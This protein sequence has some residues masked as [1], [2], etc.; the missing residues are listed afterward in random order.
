M[1]D[2]IRLG[3]RRVGIAEA[4]RRRHEDTGSDQV[5]AIAGDNGRVAGTQSPHF[6]GRRH[7]GNEMVFHAKLAERCHVGATTIAEFDNYP[8]LQ[9]LAGTVETMFVRE[10]LNL[11]HTAVPAGPSGAAGDPPAKNLVLPGPLGEPLPSLMRQL[12]RRLEQDQ[13]L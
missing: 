10:K 3:H 11:L 1:T 6:A 12:R 7:I 8:Q 5:S 9:Y 2:R 4:D 13:A